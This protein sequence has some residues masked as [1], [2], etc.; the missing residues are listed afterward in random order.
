MRVED[1]TK[2]LDQSALA[3]DLTPEQLTAVCDEVRE[4]HVAALCSWPQ[5]VPLMVEQLRGCDVKVCTVIDFPL[6]DGGSE[7]KVAQ[8]ER[9]VEEGVDEIEVVM[10]YRAMLAGDFGAARDELRA[11]TRAV[12]SRAANGGR[13]DVLIKVIIEAPRLD[14]KLSRLACLIVED[15]GADFAKTCTGVGTA[16]TVHDVE[17]M[18]DALSESVGVKAAG[19]VRTLEDVQ[20]LVGAGAARVGT[21]AAPQVLAEL[22]ALNGS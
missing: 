19:G 7:A 22:Q 13:G 14:D 20:T 4:L 6:G 5:F 3:E 11:V 1:L 15:A 12:R 9:A 10:N 17:L 2:T 18:R 21:S 16:A 8:A